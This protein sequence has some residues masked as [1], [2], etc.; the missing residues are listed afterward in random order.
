MRP[1]HGLWRSRSPRPGRCLKTKLRVDQQR[2]A[3]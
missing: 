3:I 1:K 2:T